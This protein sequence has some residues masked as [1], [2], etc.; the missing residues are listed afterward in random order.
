MRYLG[1]SMRTCLLLLSSSIPVLA[2]STP[3]PIFTIPGTVYPDSWFENLAVRPNGLILA[4]RGDAPEIW[5]IDPA[6]G[7]GAVLVTVMGAFNLTGITELTAAPCK[8][9][10][11]WRRQQQ[12]QQQQ[13]E[14]Q[15]ETYVFGSSYFLDF[16]NVVPGSA[17][18]WTL[19]FPT[20]NA[21]TP[22]TVSLLTT[23]PDAGLINGMATW[24]SGRVLLSDTLTSSIYLLD[25]ATG[26]FTTPFSGLSG[27]N[28]IRTAPGYVYSADPVLGVLSRT[29]V[30]ADAVPTGPA[31]LLLE[32]QQMDD[33]ALAVDGASGAG[34]AYVGTLMGNEVVEAFGAPPFSAL[35]VKRVVADDVSGT[36]T[37]AVTVTVFG[38]RTE[39]AGLL[40]VAVGRTGGNAAIVMVDPSE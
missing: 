17:K 35:G 30:D 16:A 33:F 24:D 19:Q 34:K 3:T 20:T 9:R 14:P 11:R 25:V 23:L 37:G 12:Q 7:E 40:Y 31:E 10:K 22:P 36:G 38:R 21:N 26:T 4:T 27:V 2:L 39:D 32:D 1:Q 6:T 5:Q 15:G 18:I 8:Q 28:G 13:T 29:P